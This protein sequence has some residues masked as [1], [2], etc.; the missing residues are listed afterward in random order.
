MK[1]VECC[2]FKLVSRESVEYF[3]FF[4]LL[5]GIQKML[6]WTILLRLMPLSTALFL[7]DPEMIHG[8]IPTSKEAL[9]ER[10]EIRDLYLKE[11]H[12]LWYKEY[13]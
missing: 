5:S 13:L 11:F 9:L 1:S 3:E 8:F 2:L 12:D 4:T 6:G 7:T 10:L